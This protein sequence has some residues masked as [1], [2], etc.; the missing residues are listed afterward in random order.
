M[1]QS[2]HSNKPFSVRLIEDLTILL[3]G[4]FFFSGLHMDS[5]EMDPVE[6]D[7]ERVTA[8]GDEFVFTIRTTAY[9]CSP[10]GKGNEDVDKEKGDQQ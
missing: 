7:E 3:G 4:A 8:F 2:E 9:Y 1:N 6:D 5:V 10:K